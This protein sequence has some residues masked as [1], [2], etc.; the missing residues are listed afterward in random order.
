ML[1]ICLPGNGP[2]LA[3]DADSVELE[4]ARNLVRSSSERYEKLATLARRGS[5]SKADLRQARLDKQVAELELAVLQQPE[6]AA[7]QRKKIAQLNYDFQREKSLT[8]KKLYQSGSIRSSYIAA[9]FTN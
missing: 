4:S 2:V 7:T 5:V 8:A 6:S 1:L 3:Q 9:N